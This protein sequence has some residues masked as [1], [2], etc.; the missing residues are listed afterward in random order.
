MEIVL[1]ILPTKCVFISTSYQSITE[2]NDCHWVSM[3]LFSIIGHWGGCC[4][5]TLFTVFVHCESLYCKKETQICS[6]SD[7]SR[8]LDTCLSFIRS[9]WVCSLSGVSCPIKGNCFGHDHLSLFQRF[10]YRLLPWISL[11]FRKVL[12]FTRQIKLTTTTTTQKLH[13]ANNRCS[14]QYEFLMQLCWLR[15]I[16]PINDS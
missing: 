11:H 16:L 4:C 1:I 13:S 14:A 5:R 8:T 10:F 7:A 2:H 3:Y 15:F 6:H 12:I 9:F